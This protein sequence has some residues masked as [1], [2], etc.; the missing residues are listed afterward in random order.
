[1]NLESQ[2][3]RKATAWSGLWCQAQGSKTD[4]RC[5]CWW[6]QDFAYIGG[7][8]TADQDRR[9]MKPAMQVFCAHS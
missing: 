6:G 7:L 9:G 1:M 2:M 5:F 4:G 8:G 3:G